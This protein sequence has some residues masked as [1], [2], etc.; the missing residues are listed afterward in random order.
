MSHRGGVREVIEN[1]TQG[2]QLALDKKIGLEMDIR[3]TKDG[4]FVLCHDG[5]LHRITG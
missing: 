3:K 2:V 5:F 1:T 4:K